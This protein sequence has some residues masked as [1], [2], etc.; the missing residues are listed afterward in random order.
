MFFEYF[1]IHE[2]NQILTELHDSHEHQDKRRL[3]AQLARRATALEQKW[4]VKTILK[5]LKLSLGHERIL[6]SLHPRAMELYSHS[7]NLQAVLEAIR[8]K[9]DSTADEQKQ[10]SGMINN[11]F[12]Q[13]IK[14]MLSFRLSP[15]RVGGV[16]DPQPAVPGGEMPP[17]PRLVLETKYDGERIVAHIDKD[18]GRL[19]LYTRNARDYT[20]MYGPAMQSHI[21]RSVQGSRA[22]LDGEMLSYDEL[23]KSF[24]PFGN[25]RFVALQLDANQHLCYMVFDILYYSNG[26]DTYDL[27]N[28][29][30]EDRRKLLEKVIA[31]IDKIVEVVPQ[32]NINSRDTQQILKEL[33]SA[34]ERHEEGLILKELSSNYAC[35]SRNRGWYKVKPEYDGL[36]EHLDLVVIGGYWS[37]TAKRR[38][39]GSTDPSDNISHFLVALLKERVSKHQLSIGVV[40]MVS[41]LTKVGTG[42]NMEELKEM[43]KRLRGIVFC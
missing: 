7:S 17:A 22:V 29:P 41:P 38:K 8:K 31:P 4:I 35:G 2:V 20:G 32:R 16:V 28:T 30:M 15:H 12:F 42:Y 11:I 13:T 1:C 40:P 23:A 10:I 39:Q 27:R 37:D 19:G 24:V 9:P 43:Q 14:P 34:I 21:F 36:G 33:D 3:I 5:D 18:A 25:N 6:R 26:E